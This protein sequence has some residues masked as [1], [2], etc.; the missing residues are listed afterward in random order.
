MGEEIPQ[1]LREAGKE[2][3]QIVSLRNSF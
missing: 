2:N 3:K 1:H